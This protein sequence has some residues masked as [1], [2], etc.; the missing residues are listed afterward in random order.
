MADDEVVPGEHLRD[1]LDELHERLAALSGRVADL[2]RDRDALLTEAEA[3]GE[4]MERAEAR[5]QRFRLSLRKALARVAATRREDAGSAL[6]PGAK[7]AGEVESAGGDE[8]KPAG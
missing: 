2:E 4:R 5:L 1:E 7:S 6:P 8:M 3:Q